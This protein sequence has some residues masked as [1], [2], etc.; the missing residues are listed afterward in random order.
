MFEIRP[1]CTVTHS[2]RRPARTYFRGARWVRPSLDL[3][4]ARC[5]CGTD[6]CRAGRTRLSAVEPPSFM[7]DVSS[8]SGCG[9]EVKHPRRDPSS[10]RQ[11]A[12]SMW[13][14]TGSRHEIPCVCGRQFR[15]RRGIQGESVRRHSAGRRSVLPL[16]CS[17]EY[18]QPRLDTFHRSFIH[19]QR[20]VQISAAVLGRPFPPPL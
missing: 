8:A 6:D 9:G 3:I 13:V 12:F 14:V 2:F 5:A 4:T 18:F 15:F 11:T 10:V 17:N 7:R 1:T 19:F 16:P 20:S